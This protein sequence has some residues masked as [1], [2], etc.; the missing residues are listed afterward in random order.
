MAFVIR[1]EILAKLR[2]T[3]DDTRCLVLEAHKERRPYCEETPAKDPRVALDGFPSCHLV[4]FLIGQVTYLSIDA[5]VMALL[6]VCHGGYVFVN[7]HGGQE[8]SPRT[9]RILQLQQRTDRRER[10]QASGYTYIPVS[11]RETI[12]DI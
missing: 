12:R 1:A 10:I 11:W 7:L 2:D 4:V 3:D 9:G 5:D 6:I 8:G